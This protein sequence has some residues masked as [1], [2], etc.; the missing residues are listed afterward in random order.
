VNDVE[1]AN[2][3][4]QG[5]A[6][7]TFSPS[8]LA[9]RFSD[10][11]TGYLAVFEQANAL[12]AAEWAKLDR[13][14]L[15]WIGGRDIAWDLAARTS[16]LRARARRRVD[17]L[18]F[19]LPPPQELDRLRQPISELLEA[20]PH[21]GQVRLLLGLMID[22]YPNGRPPNL[23]V[24]LEGLV[25]QVLAAGYPPAVVAAAC[26][27]WVATQKWLPTASELVDA[28]KAQAWALKAALDALD[29]A[30][31]LRTRILEAVAQG[32][33]IADD[34]A[35]RPALLPSKRTTTPHEARRRPR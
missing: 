33:E 17:W 34:I 8:V 12:R 24:Y 14:D 23:P 9:K 32:A 15:Q 2:P 13:D 4:S 20:R 3:A 1:L 25:D 29:R 16:E 22:R 6:V 35:A 10:L 7:V 18:L 26:D 11:R 28:C 31:K 21:V 5:G 30:A 19:V 27:R